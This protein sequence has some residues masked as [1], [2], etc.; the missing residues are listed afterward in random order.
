[1]KK[2]SEDYTVIIGCGR[3]GANIANTLSDSGKNVL[4]MDADK[5]AFRRLSPNYG[6]LSVVADGTDFE[7]LREAELG[8]ATSVIALTN[9][10]NTNIMVAQMARHLFHVKQV[11][12]RLY[13]P[14][15]EN[16]YKKFGID[17]FCPAVLSARE[18][19]KILSET[20]AAS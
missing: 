13:D 7:A 12:A 18:I 1:M 10:D 14:Q 9:H 4:I 17:T 2:K 5:D 20:E 15:R 16:V 8:K 3:L 19:D 6:G 11:I